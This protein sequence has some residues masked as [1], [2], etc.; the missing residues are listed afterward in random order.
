VLISTPW[1]M[2]DGR[3]STDER[4]PLPSSS[5]PVERIALPAGPSRD[6][7]DAI[8]QVYAE[9]DCPRLDE[10][11]RVIAADDGF[12][13][14]PRK[15]VIGKVIS[16][17]SPATQR[18]CITIAVALAREAGRTDTATL[19]AKVRDLW[20]AASTAG[21]PT[22]PSGPAR[23]GRPI[24]ACDP[25]ALEV[26]R[27]IHAS[28]N[29]GHLP[30]LPAYVER[31][32]DRR[33]REI[34][35]QV[36]HGSSRMITV[37]GTSST[38]KTRA[39]WELAQHIERREPGRWRIWHPFD[40]TRLEAAADG[41]SRVGPY[42]IVWLNEAQHY[43]AP[44]NR[45]AER[46]AAGLRTLLTDPGR[47]PVLVLATMWPQHWTALTTR[48]DDD[49]MSDP[50]GQ[51]RELLSGTDVDV[52]GAFTASDLADLGKFDDPRLRHA[53]THASGGRI[54]QY[55][56]GAPHLLD[57]Y[58][59]APPAVRAVLDAAIDASRLG[60]LP[61]IPHALLEQ[62][63]PGYLDEDER[64]EAGPDWLA[65]ALADAA[66][67]SHGTR[68]LLTPVPG[69]P[70]YRLADYIEQAGATLRARCCPP[71]SFWRAASATIRDATALQVLAWAA[72]QRGRYRHAFDLYRAS[73]ENGNLGSL[74]ALLRLD[75][76]AAEPDL[77]AWRTAAQRGEPD[78]CP[79]PHRAAAD[80]QPGTADLAHLDVA[81]LDIAAARRRAQ[82]AERSAVS[83]LIASA[84]AR[85]RAGDL[86][87]A[88]CAARQAAEHGQTGMLGRLALQAEQQGDPSGAVDLAREAADRGNPV[89]LSQLARRREHCGDTGGAA[90]LYR[91]AADRGHINA[92]VNLALL[93]ENTGNIEAADR[94]RRY[95]LD[96]AGLPAEPWGRTSGPL[97]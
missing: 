77:V 73:V 90:A 8:Y 25:F 29:S 2:L 46:I 10:L 72:E 19:A 67:R 17:D 92:V 76:A 85:L 4:R 88:V 50:H 32:H 11:A 87:A 20:I 28:A 49:G 47:G 56:A 83:T 55:L 24:S 54:V 40:P 41:I 53:G 9:A 18:D 74:T 45:L 82:D 81:H 61:V 71:T 78:R 23:P 62:A 86:D 5:R 97:H 52:P 51:A 12:P 68:G 63:A 13:A 15:D 3:M 70:V 34:A 14:A 58:Q 95:G 89:V 60:R 22:T 57:R 84:H 66:R 30:P 37:V 33:M 39:C 43:L 96:A 93:C 21:P 7:R 36:L 31:P 94:I 48:P 35:D 27:A 6:L 1:V 75:R 44:L 59:K 64:D 91:E 26:H 38:G 69:D 16:G 65:G 80:R 79:H 42:S